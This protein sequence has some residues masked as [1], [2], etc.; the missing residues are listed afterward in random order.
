MAMV[1]AGRILI[2]PRGAWDNATTY[3]MLDM[4]TASNNTSYLA[5]QASINVDPVSD[6]SQTYWQP[7]GST[8]AAD[9]ETIIDNG[10]IISVNIDG[11]SIF[12]D[13]T[14]DAIQAALSTLKDVDVTNLT[15][16][17]VLAWNSTS[18]KWE[19][20]ALS[21]SF[22][23]L[24]DVSFTNVQNGQVAKY[25]STSQKWENGD[26]AAS[27]SGLSDTDIQ[28]L[29]DKQTLLY[30]TTSQKWE[31]KASASTLSTSD[32]SPIQNKIVSQVLAD[33]VEVIGSS[34]AITYAT[35]DIFAASDGHIYKAITDI[36]SGQTLVSG[37]NCS[38][39]NI[40]EKINDI[41]DDLSDF[42]T[43]IN[44]NR[45]TTVLMQNV[46]GTPIYAALPAGYNFGKTVI[47][48]TC[49]KSDTRVFMAYDNNDAA[50]PAAYLHDTLGITVNSHSST[51]EA[52]IAVTICEYN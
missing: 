48:S 19:A 16:G 27:L 2:I 14:A 1:P 15:N 49:Y 32:T 9:G 33:T 37:G 44:V 28:N 10:G 45:I 42:Q 20:I 51:S 21:N 13:Q 11:S 7:F 25:N 5:K 8:M 29:A 22:S 6:T 34:A 26:V 18:Q 12:Y 46:S 30:N 38:I 39:T 52:R 47:L 24:T 4:V 35:G 23:G 43:N 50:R 36:T 31:N 40:K 3:Q 17:K 41:Y